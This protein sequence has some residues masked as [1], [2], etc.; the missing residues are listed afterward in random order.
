MLKTGA[1]GWL[2]PGEG[3]TMAGWLA[4]GEGVGREGVVGAP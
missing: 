2:V 3:G 4:L 1:V